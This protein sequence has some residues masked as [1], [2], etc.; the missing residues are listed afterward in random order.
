MKKLLTLILACSFVLTFAQSEKNFLL[1][2]D[3]GYFYKHQ[4]GNESA[5]GITQFYGQINR[6]FNMSFSA[7]RK[8][9]S[10][11]YFGLGLQY[12]HQKTVINPEE[13]LPDFTPNG[14]GY[15]TMYLIAS[16]TTTERTVSPFVYV[17]YKKELTPWMALSL[18][19]YSQYG[20]TLSRNENKDNIQQ[21][22]VNDTTPGNPYWEYD[23]VFSSNTTQSEQKKQMLYVGLTPSIRF[24]V[25][26][27]AGISLSF[28][29][30]EYATK[31][32]DTH[33]PDDKG[34]NN[35]FDLSF[36][37]SNWK[38]GFFVRL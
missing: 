10:N 6:D 25:L 15:V 16:Y 3:V 37:P 28:G 24:L 31:T 14:S 18:D 19:L 35:S 23:I 20:Y 17:E 4:V 36:S 7:A 13:D 1:K 9:K 21:I 12:R 27:N 5:T 32:K 11:F 26:K 33:A 30:I 29:K 34:K 2:A 38:L 8:F 22:V